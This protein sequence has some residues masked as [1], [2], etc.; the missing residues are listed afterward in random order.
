MLDHCPFR[1]VSITQHAFS[2]VMRWVSLRGKV[3]ASAC[4]TA[5]W[6]L[7]SAV[8]SCQLKGSRGQ[9]SEKDEEQQKKKKRNETE[10]LPQTSDRLTWSRIFT[11]DLQLPYV[12]IR[13]SEKK[14]CSRKRERIAFQSPV[15]KVCID[16]IARVI[17]FA[18]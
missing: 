17:R 4:C 7:V 10:D 3:T 1:S 2:G 6:P 12:F 5:A 9:P 11:A 15:N 14:N 13:V 8:I 16:L 18:V